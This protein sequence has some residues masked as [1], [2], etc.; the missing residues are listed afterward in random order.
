[1]KVALGADHAGYELKEH[2][3]RWLVEHGHEVVDFGTDSTDSVDYPDYAFA[4]SEAV[5]TGKADVGVLSC[6]TGIGV[7]IA[8]NKVPG[9]RAALVNDPEAAVLSREHNSANVLCMGGRRT[10]PAQANAIL[11]A[12]F[13]TAFAGGRHARRVDKIMKRDCRSR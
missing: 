5:S 3:K 8:A 7:S 1:M 13:A 4:A 6:G 11:E 2:V 9:I 10:T 12:W